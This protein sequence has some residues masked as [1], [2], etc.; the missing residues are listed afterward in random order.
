MPARPS[1][2]DA[3]QRR[4]DLAAIHA[5]AK[6][7]ALSDDEYRDLMATVCGGV[8]SA[9]ALDIAGRQRFLRHLQQCL[10]ASGRGPARLVRAPLTPDQRK[11]W[12][13]WM[14][15]ADAGK[16]HQRTMSALAAFAQRQTGV[17]RL[18]WLNAR[19]EHL[20]IESL[21]AWLK[22]ADEPTA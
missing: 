19:Q 1:P 7:L 5:A 21:K 13:L 16:V 17:S 11:M 22:R 12:A 3:D 18:E 10:Q 4:R 2:V 15:L 20:V 6:Q 14:Q 8:R 9:G